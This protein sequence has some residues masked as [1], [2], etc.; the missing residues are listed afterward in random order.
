MFR[1]SNEKSGNGNLEP[2]IVGGRDVPVV[3]LRHKEDLGPTDCLTEI[4]V[5]ICGME[6]QSK[7]GGRSVQDGI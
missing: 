6:L 1:K 3:E 4:K 5:H 2:N 7:Q